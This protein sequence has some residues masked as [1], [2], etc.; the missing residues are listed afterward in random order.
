MNKFTIGKVYPFKVIEIREGNDEKQYIYLSDGERDTYRVDP[1][2]YQLE[3]ER[4][5]LP[6]YLNCYVTSLSIW[7]LPTLAQVRQ[8]VLAS[9][10]TELNSEYAFKVLAVREDDSTS[11]TYY[12]LK[13]PF[14]IKHRYYPPKSEAIREVGDIFS[15]LVTGIEDKGKNKAYLKLKSVVELLATAPVIVEQEAVA[16]PRKE[17]R[18]GYESETKEF[19]STIVY[20]AGDIKPD[21]DKQM[22]YIAKTIA[23]FQNKN[24]GDLYIGVNDSGVIVGINHD[25]PYLNSSRVDTHRYH[26]N[27]DGYENK[28]RSSVRE[29]LGSTSNSNLSFSFQKESKLDYCQISIKKVLKPIFLNE[30]KLYQRAGNMT[31]LLKGDEI[32]WFIEERFHERNQL[33]FVAKHQNVDAEDVEPESIKP[34]IPIEVLPVVEPEPVRTTAKKD[35]VWYYLT[36]YKTGDWSF[37]D[38]EVVNDQ[39]AYELPI[40]ESFKKEMTMIVYENGCVNA[41]CAYEIINPKGRKGRSLKTKGKR[42]SNGW[43]TESAIKHVFCVGKKDLIA[44]RSVQRDGTEWVK[45]H[46]VS[47]IT[48]HGNL[49]LKGNVIINP[50]LE[51][52]IV[53]ST[54]ISVAYYHLLS[55][56]ILKD[57][58]TSGYLGF[59]TTERNYQKTIKLLDELQS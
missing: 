44:F 29:L 6:A 24:G 35:K 38:N 2:D 55:S 27:I 25:F 21:I 4:N 45:I 34:I 23:G 36:F 9:C 56:L 17:S 40:M 13:D 33:H 28:I 47:A 11:A 3:W 30:S 32:S 42:Y 39:V 19:K 41:V 49:H 52:S 8:E 50:N 5:S 31:Q 12:E 1:F 54:P 14:G 26:E 46:Q 22:L 18:F 58:Q 37:Q 16:D 20:P 59:K 7:D 57:Y 51:A 15:L 43:N 10:Y 48:E 53:S